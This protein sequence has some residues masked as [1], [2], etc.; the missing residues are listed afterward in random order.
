M[1]NPHKSVALLVDEGDG[2]FTDALA[3]TA[4]AIT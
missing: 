1:S 2:D 4:E 3:A